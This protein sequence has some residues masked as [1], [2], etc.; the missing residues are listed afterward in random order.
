MGEIDRDISV[1]VPLLNE[2]GSLEQLHA[3]LVDA[4]EGLGRDYEIV[5]VDDGSTDSSPKILEDLRAED[6]N[7]RVI[8]FRRNF[9]K[10]A[11]LSAGFQH[12]RGRVIITMDADL[13]DDPKEIPNFLEKIDEGYDI[14]SGW[15][16]QR[17]DPLSKRL[18][19]RFFNS[20][21]S[22]FSG[23]RLHD[24]NC[25]F[26][27]YR[28]EVVENIH[29][30]G[31]LHRYIPVLAHWKGFRVGEIK[32]RHHKR[33]YGRSKYGL[34]RFLRGGLDFLTVIL[35]TKY[36]RRPLH[37]FGGIGLF[38]A[39]LGFIADFYLTILWFLGHGIGTRPLL[40]LGVLLIILGIQF[41]S[42]GLIGEMVIYAGKRGEDYVIKRI[43]G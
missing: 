30:Y 33:R 16:F 13:Q 10:S 41:I 38:F 7:V 1:V 34:V 9:G 3:G 39:F 22:A 24:F 4:L 12:S 35:I 15:K 40:L 14:V 2:E 42:M 6:R 43:L 26:K 5:F 29:I 25:G 28:R 19:S 23:V 27:A 20:F 18:P 17:Q 36:F 37:F 32:V 11:A 31:E 8:Q 21:V